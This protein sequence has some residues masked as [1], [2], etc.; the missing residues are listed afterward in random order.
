MWFGKPVPKKP[1]ESAIVDILQYPAIVI[2]WFA[3]NYDVLAPPTSWLRQSGENIRQVIENAITAG[4]KLREEQ[5]RLGIAPEEIAQMEAKASEKASERIAT[6][7]ANAI[8]TKYLGA[9]V[10]ALPDNW[11]SLAPALATIAGVTAEIQRRAIVSSPQMRK[12]TRS[13]FGDILHLVYLPYVDV[14]RLDGPMADILEHSDAPPS[15]KA[16]RRLDNLIE[17]IEVA[18][19]ETGLG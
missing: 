5:V 18:L 19:A 7:L 2:E 11:R 15:G 4:H 1:L 17:T 6:M 14:F 12:P 10:T 13:D 8:S 9:P 3:C 16:V